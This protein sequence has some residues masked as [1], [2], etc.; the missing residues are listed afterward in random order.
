MSI[1]KLGKNIKGLAGLRGFSG[2]LAIGIFCG[3]VIAAGGGYRLA[4]LGRDQEMVRIASSTIYALFSEKDLQGM[5]EE[6][7][8][9]KAASLVLVGSKT[10]KKYYASTCGGVKRIKPEN[11]ITFKNKE[12]ALK[13]GYTPAANC[14]DVEEPQPP[15]EQ[16]DVK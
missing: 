15:K 16:S 5:A 11:L 1:P 6:E 8:A 4:V 12:E 10:G 7:R 14:P 3:V 2:V 9:R 13:K